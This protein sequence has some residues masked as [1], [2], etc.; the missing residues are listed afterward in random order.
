[1]KIIYNNSGRGVPAANYRGAGSTRWQISGDF[2]VF[3]LLAT[4]GRYLFQILAAGSTRWQ[5]SGGESPAE[6]PPLANIG[7]LLRFF[8][9]RHT[10][11]LFASNSDLSAGLVVGRTSLIHRKRSP[12]LRACITSANKTKARFNNLTVVRVLGGI[13]KR[14]GL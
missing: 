2:A 4:R 6:K 12:F 14:E 8:L 5:L 1:M 13:Q 11:A 10:A 7:V 9:A 3:P